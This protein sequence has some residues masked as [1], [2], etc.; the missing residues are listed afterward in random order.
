MLSRG[1]RWGG[2]PK[3]NQLFPEAFWK[4]LDGSR[5]PDI[6][7]PAGMA[8][9]SVPSVRRPLHW[10]LWRKRIAGGTSKRRH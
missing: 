7:L 3:L 8:L 2:P 5:R 9:P 1:V 4:C 10:E 6:A